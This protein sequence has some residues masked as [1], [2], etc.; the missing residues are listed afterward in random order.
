[1]MKQALPALLLLLAAS[2][3]QA[4]EVRGSMTTLLAGR[5]DVRGADVVSVIPL[6]ELVAL[7]VRDFALPGAD[8]AR[9]VL[10][11]WGRL[12][13][14]NDGGPSPSDEGLNPT[15]ADLGLFYLEANRGP[16]ELRLGRQHLVQGVGRMQMIDGASLEARL[17]WG[18]SA[19]GFY[20]LTVQPELR[21]ESDDGLG[22][23]R[24]AKRLPGMGEL[25]IGYALR[26]SHG[27]LYRQDLGADAFYVVGP[28][29]WVGLA[30]VSPA[31]EG[32]LRLTEARLA[33]TYLKGDALVLTVDGERVA[34]D[35]L[36]NRRSIFTVFAIGNY[37]AFGGDLAYRP[38]PYYEL[39][40]DGHLLR[41]NNGGLGYRATAQLNAY[42]DPAHRSRIGVE[43]SRL[44]EKE[45]GYVRGRALASLELASA[46]RLAGDVFV[47]RFD[48]PVNA[49]D[50]SYIGQMSVVY[51]LSRSMRVVASVAGGSTP[52]AE[53][54]VEGMLR[55][56]YG[57][58]V[59]FDREVTP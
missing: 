36:L 10:N 45:S 33:A 14:G 41:R 2:S 53:S 49:Y 8:H 9:L 39:T 22:G 55:F 1:M 40:L 4:T 3:A 29:R 44:D 51:D 59:D 43:V 6:Y 19:Q 13:L 27:E 46:L 24:L 12:Q 23:G 37:D 21:I 26:T 11:G 38:S 28:T 20:G 48:E 32:G 25:G 35:L 5:E 34:P 16:V 18:L 57:Y 31:E 30:V 47:Y 15:T 42:R 17:P 54:Q 56:A 7:E 50:A 58:N 52:F